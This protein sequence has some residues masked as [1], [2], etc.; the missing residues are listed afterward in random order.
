M[1]WVKIDD[2][3]CD[4]PKIAAVGAVGAWLQ[5]QALCYCNRNLTDGFVPFG[6][7][8]SFLGRGVQRLDTDERIWALAE[9]CGMAGRDIGESPWP[10]MMV[11]A[12][13]WE[14][15]PGGYR[16]H[17]YKDYQRS[18]A[19]VLADRKR[20]AKNQQ[21]YQERTKADR[22]SDPVTDRAP[23]PIP[24]PGSG[25]EEQKK[26][27]IARKE[28]PRAKRASHSTTWPDDFTL[29]EERASWARDVGIEVAWEWNKFKDFHHAKGSRFLDW[30]A[31]WRTWIRNAVDFAERGVRRR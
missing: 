2:G 3:F 13:L 15:A 19:E 14:L 8:E 9:T 23:V 17:D 30:N 26:L 10:A 25:E 5:L 24:I 31:A 4:H 18:K 20:H 1:S 21:A 29:T 6:V 16:I 11:N 27:A 28:K 7:A 12:R 22:V